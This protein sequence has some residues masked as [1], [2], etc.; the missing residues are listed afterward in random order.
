MVQTSS[1]S[2]SESEYPHGCFGNVLH[3]LTFGLFGN[4][5]SRTDKHVET[6]Y[7]IKPKDDNKG[8]P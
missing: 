2:D 1:N 5:K 4:Q 7:K 6:E 8:S 3:S